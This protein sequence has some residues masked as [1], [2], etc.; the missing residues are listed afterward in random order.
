MLE[1]CS[2]LSKTD[3]KIYYFCQHS[4]NGKMAKPFYF[5]QTVSKRPNLADLTFK[6]AKWQPCLP[7]LSLIPPPPSSIYLFLSHFLFISLSKISIL[8][9]FSSFICPL[10]FFLS[11][12][13]SLDLSFVQGILSVPGIP[14]YE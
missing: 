14:G 11:F 2:D 8:F 7:R 1:I 6:T 3:L 12:S 4:K 10:S 5:W 13:L 9:L